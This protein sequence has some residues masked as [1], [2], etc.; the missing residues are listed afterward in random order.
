MQEDL[1]A[2]QFLHFD[3]SLNHAKKLMI[4]EIKKKDK[5]IL[6]IV[7]FEPQ[8]LLLTQ[9]LI[10]KLLISNFSPQFHLYLHQ[11]NP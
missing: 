7:G 1:V 2:Y 6:K 5:D 3:S 11:K 9:R 10:S 8:L 4:E